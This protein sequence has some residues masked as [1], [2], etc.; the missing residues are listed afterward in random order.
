MPSSLHQPNQGVDL[1]HISVIELLHRVFNLLLAGLDIRIDPGVRVSS[2]FLMADLVVMGELDDGIVVKLLTPG[3]APPR[4]FGLPP[5]P[6][7]F[8]PMEGDAWIFSFLWLWTPCSTAFLAFKALAWALEGAG[9]SFFKFGAVFVK[10]WL[11]L[12]L[13]RNHV[14]QI[15]FLIEVTCSGADFFGFI[16]F[17][18]CLAS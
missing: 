13:M 12:F 1:S 10:I 16:L 7:C 15:A 14:F 18:A 17:G 4:T 11:L 2:V 9:A 6:Q 3:S 5:E 8:W